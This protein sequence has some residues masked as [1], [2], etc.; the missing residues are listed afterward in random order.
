MT[1]AEKKI[2][3][4]QDWEI[5]LMSSANRISLKGMLYFCFILYKLVRL[6]S[7]VNKIFQSQQVQFPF[8][9]YILSCISLAAFYRTRKNC[10]TFSVGWKDIEISWKRVKI[11]LFFAVFSQCKYEFIFVTSIQN[12]DDDAILKMI[13]DPSNGMVRQLKVINH[14]MVI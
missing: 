8:P 10:Q 7:Y 12:A 4:G 2:S 6:S 14:L 13:Y 11:V 9:A 1:D 3:S 5:L